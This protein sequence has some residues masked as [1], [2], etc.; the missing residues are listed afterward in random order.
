MV[1]L[2]SNRRPLILIFLTLFLDLLGVGIL[3]PI[4]P[5]LVRHFRS[6]AL[7]IGLLVLV[8]SAA[9]FLMTPV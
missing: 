8:F 6:D 7:T 4:T 3:I 9:Q 2:L 1:K 5:Y